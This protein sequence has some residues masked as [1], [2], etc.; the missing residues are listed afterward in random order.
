M[1]QAQLTKVYLT[2]LER[3]LTF[4]GVVNKLTEVNNNMQ[5]ILT[6]VKVYEYESSN[7]LYSL[8]E[9]SFTRPKAVLHIEAA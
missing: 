8:P 4:Y 6:D 3:N 5:V 1:D 9:I 2:D 7:Y